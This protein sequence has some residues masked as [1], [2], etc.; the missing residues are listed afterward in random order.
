M[1]I[2]NGTLVMAL[3]GTKL[4]LFRNDGD[5][6]YPV[7]A[8]L[9]HEE[10]DNPPSREHGTDKPG[11]THASMGDGRS[12][13]YGETDWHE[14]TLQRFIRHA[15]EV[16][17]KAAA[18]KPDAGIVVIAPPNALGELRKQYGR[19]TGDRLLAEIGKDLA[20]HM[21][22]DIEKAIAAHKS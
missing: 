10:A 12:S 5:D 14:Q 2:D 4:L 21:T 9:K 22:D 6:K 8:T 19:E 13:S 3:D 18:G 20:N 15:A 17:E 1:K 11:R 7:L 16:L